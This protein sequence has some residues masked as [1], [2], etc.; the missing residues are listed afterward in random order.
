LEGRRF[1][2]NRPNVISE[3]FDDEVV[4]INFETGSYYGMRGTARDIWNAL[5]S[6]IALDTL[7][8]RYQGDAGTI[9]AEVERFLERLLDEHLVAPRSGAPSAAGGSPPVETRIPWQSPALEI[10]KDMQDLLLLDPIHEVD[11]T[12]WPARKPPAGAPE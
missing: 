9:A 10:Y 8:A 7:A 1:R 11:E 4:A 12:G 5:D 2:I 3:V 6:E